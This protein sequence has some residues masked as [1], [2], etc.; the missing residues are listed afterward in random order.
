MIEESEY[1]N[2][3][4]ATLKNIKR[5]YY[6]VSRHLVNLYFANKNEVILRDTK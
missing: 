4:E 6:D 2:A 3:F 1:K 5:N